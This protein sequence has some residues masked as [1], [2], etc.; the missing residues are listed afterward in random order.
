MCHCKREDSGRNLTAGFQYLKGAYTQEGDQLFM[1][2][3]S[4]RTRRKVFKLPREAVGAP[5]LEMFKAR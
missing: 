4:D 1:R 3:D 5:F 2:S